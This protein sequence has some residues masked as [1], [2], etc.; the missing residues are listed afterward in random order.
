MPGEAIEKG[1]PTN[2]SAFLRKKNIIEV[3]P[4]KISNKRKDRAAS[5]PLRGGSPQ[6][7]EGSARFARLARQFFLINTRYK[8][9]GRLALFILP[10]CSVGGLAVRWIYSFMEKE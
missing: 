4:T 1:K 5:P 9:T 3:L 10:L 7:E 2:R 8:S 6:P